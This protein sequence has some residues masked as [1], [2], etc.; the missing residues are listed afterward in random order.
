MP[1]NKLLKPV[2]TQWVIWV[3]GEEYLFTLILLFKDTL[4]TLPFVVVSS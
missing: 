1:E 3:A 4:N 2:I